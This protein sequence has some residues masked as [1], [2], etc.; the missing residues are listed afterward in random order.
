[1]PIVNLHI[2]RGL[3]VE[4]KRTLVAEI[5]QTLARVAGAKPAR[6]HIVIQEVA[7]EDWGLE[8]QLVLDRRAAPP[9]TA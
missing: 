8:G 9:A 4:Q 6:T 3:S 7:D 5:T 1:M 2:V